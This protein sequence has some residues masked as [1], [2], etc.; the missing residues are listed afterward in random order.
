MKDI[1]E[2][3]FDNVNLLNFTEYIIDDMI[4]FCLYDYEDNLKFYNTIY[5]HGI[6]VADMCDMII[7]NSNLKLNQYEYEIF[8]N[9]VVFY[10]IGK[11]KDRH[12]HEYHGSIIY[13]KILDKFDNIP[14]YIKNDMCNIILKH[15]FKKNKPENMTMLEK[16]MMDADYL[17]ERCGDSALLLITQQ[18]KSAKNLNK[19]NMDEVY[20]R[21]TKLRK[22]ENKVLSILNLEVSKEIYSNLLDFVEEEI[23]KLS[24]KAKKESLEGFNKFNQCLHIIIK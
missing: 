3:D 12:N 14:D 10:D 19:Y 6:R 4:N 2:Y 7:N 21:L 20:N 22:N 9:T 1:Y 15:G 17:D 16:I 11:L 18:L 5:T 13:R 23:D 8:M 24:H